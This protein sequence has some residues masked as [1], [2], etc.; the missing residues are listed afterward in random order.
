GSGQRERAEGLG[1]GS[2]QRERAEGVGRGRGAEGAGRGIGQRER[3]EGAGRGSEHGIVSL[4]GFHGEYLA[5]RHGAKTSVKHQPPPVSAQFCGFNLQKN[6]RLQAGGRKRS[7]GRERGEVGRWGG[8]EEGSSTAPT[9]A[10]PQ[11]PKDIA[12]S[13]VFHITAPPDTHSSL[14]RLLKHTVTLTEHS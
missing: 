11:C 12:L 6:I 14:L 2:G 3:A 4:L 1:R 5:H 7:Q 8:G 13:R 9:A 10:S